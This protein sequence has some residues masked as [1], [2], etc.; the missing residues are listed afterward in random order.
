MV[1]ENGG[2]GDGIMIAGGVLKT[3][4]KDRTY[5]PPLIVGDFSS[6]GYALMLTLPMVSQ[7]KGMQISRWPGAT[8]IFYP[9]Q[10]HSKEHNE[11]ES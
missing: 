4:L 5:S 6:V 2:G 1:I 7:A 11:M 9:Y 10:S 3:H 8:Y